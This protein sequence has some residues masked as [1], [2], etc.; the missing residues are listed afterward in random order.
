MRRA[1]GVFIENVDLPVHGAGD[2]VVRHDV[3]AGGHAVE[4]QHLRACQLVHDELA[5]IGVVAEE[6]RRVGKH[7][8]L[9]DLPVVGGLEVEIR[10]KMHPVELHDHALGPVFF[11]QIGQHFR[12]EVFIVQNLL[13]D[14]L[15]GVGRDVVFDLA[16]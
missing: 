7:D 12:A 16:N 8:L 1:V 15:V 14:L 5:H 2:L 9:R 3:R 11:L 6:G 4:N 13:V 10:S